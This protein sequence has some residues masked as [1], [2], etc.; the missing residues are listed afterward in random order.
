[1][2]K[3]LIVAA[4]VALL[5]FGYQQY[6]KRQSADS[7][8]DQVVTVNTNSEIANV[9]NADEANLHCIPATTIEQITN[10]S[11]GLI[12][13]VYTAQLKILNCSY[14]S[15]EIV[16]NVKPTVMYKLQ[17]TN[18]ANGIWSRKQTA[19]KSQPS[20]ADSSEF[21]DA[22][23][24]INPVKEINQ[25]TF[26]GRRGNKYVE[27]NYTPVSEGQPVLFN[28]GNIILEKVLSN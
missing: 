25:G 5:Y 9:A 4:A 11:F 1:M 17:L 18:D 21:G 15:G 14:E 20:Y 6:Q 28:R 19:V 13:E 7:F 26:Y 12:S 10:R 23:A 24:N 22:F 8:E 27:L 16:D 2:Q 3:L